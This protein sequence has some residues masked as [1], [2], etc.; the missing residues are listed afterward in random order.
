MLLWLQARI[1]SPA[2]AN[3]KKSSLKDTLVFS[4]TKRQDPEIAKVVFDRRNECR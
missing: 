3:V 2:T 1:Q 4:Y